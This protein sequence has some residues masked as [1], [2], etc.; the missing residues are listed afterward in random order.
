MS[1]KIAC[2][3]TDM[4]EDSEYTEP[5]KSYKEAGHEVITIE[6]EAGKVVKGNKVMISD[7]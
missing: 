6:S 4:F 7:N 3:I 5:A 1:K 2:L